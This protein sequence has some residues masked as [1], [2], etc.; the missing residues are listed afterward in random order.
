MEF[1]T[2]TPEQR[3]KLLADPE[4]QA[5]QR[6][7]NATLA[8]YAARDEAKAAQAAHAVALEK[9]TPKRLELEA[10]IAA[11]RGPLDAAEHRLKAAE[12]A[13]A[14]AEEAVKRT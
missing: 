11:L 5:L 7:M 9:F 4:Y 2:L 3:Q 1:E 13:L 6:D 14:E 10:R 12:A 8:L